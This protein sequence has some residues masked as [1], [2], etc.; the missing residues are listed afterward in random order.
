MPASAER[1]GA[2]V[3]DLDEVGAA[4]SELLVAERVDV[5]LVACDVFGL[6]AF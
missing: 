4:A 2:A 6:C 1:S 5:Q 3:Q